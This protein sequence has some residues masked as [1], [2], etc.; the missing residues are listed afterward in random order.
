MA[1]KQEQ[2]KS[3]KNTQKAQEKKVSDKTFG[4][5]NK[6]RSSVVRRQ[7]EQ[8]EAQLNG[9]QLK[10]QA[11]KERLNAEKKAAEA[12][13]AE[14]RALFSRV[15][16]VQK[17]EIGVDPKSVVCAY[18]KQ[19]LCSKGA[20]CKFS[21]DLSVERKGEKR[22]LYSDKREEQAADTMDKWDE[23]KLQEVILS[24]HGNPKTTTDKICKF[25]IE[26][27]ENGKYGWF[28]IC[29]NGGDTCKYRHSLPA[30]FKLKTKEEQRLERQA[31]A[32]APIVTL[33]EFIETER[34]RLP[35]ERTPITFESFSKWKAE[36]DS[37]K[38]K[39][40]EEASKHK[41]T[42]LSG[43]ELMLSGRFS[44]AGADET[45]DMDTWDLAAM[46]R[47]TELE[48]EASE[49]NNLDSQGQTP[50]AV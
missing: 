26:A 1:K 13:K 47:Q 36:F 11:E 29:P 19:G 20:K 30:G 33:E 15:S 27:V 25:F 10:K 49:L 41:K 45:E 35:K 42:V 2:K 9:Q 34:A 50:I 18:F 39:S 44:G 12:A 28:W 3:A 24:K 38:A 5:K 23:K 22:D 46:R 48:K 31:A 4:L 43:R 21:H 6:N 37:K 8:T 14:A 32:A 7:V 16:P 40:A 17:V